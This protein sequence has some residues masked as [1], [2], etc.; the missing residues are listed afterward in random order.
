MPEDREAGQRFW[1]RRGTAFPCFTI[2]RWLGRKY[3]QNAQSAVWRSGAFSNRNRSLAGGVKPST[4][5]FWECR[6]C[7]ISAC[8][9]VKIEICMSAGIF[10]F[11]VGDELGACFALSAPLAGTTTVP[12]HVQLARR[13]ATVLVWSYNCDMGWPESTCRIIS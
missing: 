7:F 4:A 10:A 11:G 12:L 13:G 3:V 2:A 5:I 8:M 6:Y 1:Q 9:G